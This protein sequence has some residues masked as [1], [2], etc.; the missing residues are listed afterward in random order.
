RDWSH[1]DFRQVAREAIEANSRTPFEEAVW[2]QLAKGFRFV[3]GQ[4]GDEDSFARLADTVQRLDV[5]RGTG[6]NH[7]FYLS[8]P[9]SQFPAVCEQLSRSGL[10]TPKPGTWRRV[11]RKST[12][13]NSSHVSISY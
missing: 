10:S 3:Q 6:G 2:E 13:L 11:D 12:R 4:F 9:P 7:A 1:D 8:V 5:E